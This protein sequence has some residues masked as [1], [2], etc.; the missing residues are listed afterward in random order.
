MSFDR[1]LYWLYGKA[2][3]KKELDV[4]LSWAD[5]IE[6]DTPEILNLEGSDV[7]GKYFQEPVSLK[8]TIGDYEFW[9][10]VDSGTT[11]QIRSDHISL[12]TINNEVVT[13]DGKKV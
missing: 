11:Y 9:K 12:F 8:E 1:I 3:E 4:R 10:G 6:T 7:Y 13:L 2:N 5:L